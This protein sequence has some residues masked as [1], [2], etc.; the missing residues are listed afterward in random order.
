MQSET[1]IVRDKAANSWRLWARLDEQCDSSEDCYTVVST[2][3]LDAYA[4]GLAHYLYAC[5]QADVEAQAATFEQVTRYI[6]SLLPGQPQAIA[7]ATLQQRLSAIRLWYDHLVLLEQRSHN[8]VPRAQYRS[9]DPGST[10]YARGLVPRLVKLPPVPIDADWQR[11]LRTAQA[12]S[13]RDRLMLALAYYGALRRAELVALRI[14]DLDVAQRLIHLRAETTKS[15]RARVVCYS[16]AIASL[17]MAHLHALRAAGWRGGALFCSCSDRNHGQ[18]LTGWT[19]SKTVAAW[20]TQ[21][22]TSGISTHSFR[23]LRLTHLARAG[24]KL[25]ELSTYAGHRDPKTTVAYLHLSGADLNAKMALS[26][27][28]QDERLAAILFAI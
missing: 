11:F 10:G 15:R 22:Q 1:R 13:L 8:P 4:R 18:P 26:M 28:N 6:G 3:T 12:G 24:W 21:A 9:G 19:W 16:P 23:H 20:A 14:E 17:L 27:A 7:N 5:E 2:A 25:H